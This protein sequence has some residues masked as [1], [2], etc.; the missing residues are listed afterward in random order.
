MALGGSAGCCGR[1]LA[2]ALGGTLGHSWP[3]SEISLHTPCP[4]P[5][6]SLPPLAAPCGPCPQL[7]GMRY[8]HEV[9]RPVISRVFEEKKYMELDPSKMDLNRSR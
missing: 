2:S 1:C 6:C 8:L 7:V 3:G 9:L 4:S 5:G